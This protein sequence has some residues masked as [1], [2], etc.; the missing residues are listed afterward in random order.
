MI[1]EITSWAPTVA[2]SS[3]AMPA[4][5]APASVASTIATTTCRSRGIPAND[6]PTHT[7]M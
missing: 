1:V 7:A 5:A 2:F 4:H 6:E 3:P